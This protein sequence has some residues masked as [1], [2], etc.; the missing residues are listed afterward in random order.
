MSELLRRG[1]VVAGICLA[2]LILCFVHNKM[3]LGHQELRAEIKASPT[4][5]NVQLVRI[6]DLAGNDEQATGAELEQL[7][8]RLKAHKPL[9]EIKTKEIALNPADGTIKVVLE[10]GVDAGEFAARVASKPYRR[11]NPRRDLFHTN[12]GIDL[13]GGVEFIAQLYNQA[14]ERVGADDEVV[15]ILRKRLDQ[16][17]LVEPTVTRL[18]TGDV[19]IVIP[20]GTSADAARTRKVIETTGTLEFR[21]VI[22]V[23]DGVDL[24]AANSKVVQLPN[25]TYKFGPDVRYKR[26]EIVAPAKPDVPGAQPTTF[27]RLSPA[28]L[29]GRD[30]ESAGIGLR[31]GQPSV[32]INFNTLGAAKN[33]AFTTEVKAKAG[34]QAGTGRLAI[35]FDGVVETA[36][37]VIQPSAA[38]CEISG[39]FTKEEADNLRTVLKGGA[40]EVTPVVL[41]ERQV[42]AT[43]GAD[44]VTR[45]LATMGLSYLAILL[46]MMVY[47][48]R[49]GLVAVSC[50]LL[51]SAL[52]WAALSMFG[53]T[54][55]LPGLAGLLLSVAMSM[56]TNVLVFER[57]R[58]E[59]R[60]G[61]DL[62]TA[63][64]LG[65]DRAWLAIL[66]SNLT[67]VLAG[68][69]LYW[70]GS[71]PVKGFGLTLC[72]GVT[73]S[74][75]S[76]VYFGRFLTELITR[77]RTTVSMASFIK[78]ARLPY[79]R[80]R[81]ASYL[82]S[83]VTG[84]FGFGYF[85]FGH[86]LPGVGGGF[87]RNFDI[88]FTG[89]N[90]AHAIFARPIDA[91]E[92]RKRLDEARA[93]L[94]KQAPLLDAEELAAPQAYYPQLGMTGGSQQWVFRGRDPD[95]SKLEE[96]RAR[97][98]DLRNQERRK[99]IE[100]RQAENPD[101]VAA[102]RIERQAE[103]TYGPQIRDLQR[104]IQN[105]TSE[106]KRQLALA[107]A[108]LLPA[109][110]EHLRG[111]S[112]Q[113]KTLTLRL[114]SLEKPDAS[115]IER[116]S[117]RLRKDQRFTDVQVT[118][119]AD[120]NG[121]VVAA[122]F[123]ELPAA[124]PEAIPQESSPA[125]LHARLLQLVGGEKPDAR[126][127]AAAQAALGL[128][129]VIVD[130]AGN[131]RLTIAQAWP[132]SEHFS[133]QVAGQMKMRAFIALAIAVIAMLAY[134]AARFEVGFGIGAV[135]ALVHDVM[136]TLGVLSLLHV[137][138]DLTV[139]A[140]LLTVIGYSVND[141]VVNY[142]RIRENL[143]LMSQKPLAEIIDLS[144]A[145]TIPRTL[146]TGGATILAIIAMIIFAGESLYGFSVT[147]LIGTIFGTY[148]SVF[149]AAPLLLQF[150]REKLMG[151]PD[152][153]PTEPTGGAVAP[154]PAPATT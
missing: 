1:L 16:R 36:P 44:A 129:D 84:V 42:G 47:Y 21:E 145:Q 118:P 71:G 11:E 8:T 97:I 153:E 6:K 7:R 88:E 49:L 67:T 142:D 154:S 137:R 90:M 25:G 73:I 102:A 26:G 54:I 68:L 109:E 33:H 43:L 141:T 78:E 121:I 63:V 104:Q 138:I 105:R 128:H 94:G 29:T 17:G 110:G 127:Q 143:K 140:S 31:D 136:L 59:L 98:E 24:K 2:A 139:V 3:W 106:F 57:I 28:M 131:A 132:A 146:L 83:I 91:G 55:T 37:V 40:L 51:T 10:P 27:Y 4:D 101:L 82:I 46:F 148:S 135:V 144:V 14:N 120:G 130:A 41:S 5:A 111:A 107:F 56:D 147:L 125:A 60:A 150:S 58:E 117:T 76:G 124:T 116:V 149:V 92:V 87:E 81:K 133:G 75:F 61:K 85:A 119:F 103:E 13:R 62:R 45:T 12:S 99:A 20:G 126:A 96:E 48:R 108:D 30:V 93:K 114:A 152:E 19:H 113:D 50:M 23:Y 39:S 66:D 65:Y 95:G 72:I 9:R 38:S 15:G 89:G 34:R 74:M 69:I 18:S 112:L 134:I 123:H 64:D 115:Q 79:V 77:R 122:T 70:I 100:L 22:E 53:A 80:W 86:L 151:P 52:T 32:T 35:L